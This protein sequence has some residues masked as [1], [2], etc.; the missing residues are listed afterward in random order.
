MGE[1][2]PHRQL[3]DAF[4]GQP[5]GYRTPLTIAGSERVAE[6]AAIYR[7]IAGRWIRISAE[8]PEE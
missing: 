7:E 5:I 6:I 8:V 1:Q 3:H 2:G 4:I